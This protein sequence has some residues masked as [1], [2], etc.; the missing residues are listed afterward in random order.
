MRINSKSA[1]VAVALL[2]II[3]FNSGCREEAGAGPAA[4]DFLLS[5]LS[6]KMISLDQ[7]R[8]S[9]VILDF[10]ATWCG[11]CRMS[12][13]ELVKLN[14]KHGDKG[15][16]ILGVSLDDP[17]RATDEQLRAFKEQTKINYRI[18]RYN[19]KLVQDYFGTGRVSIPTM[20]VID[21]EGKISD[22]LVGFKAGVVEKSLNR[23][24]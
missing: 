11:P 18:L 12:I 7:F 24:L 1:I 10:W 8:G 5:D 21:R 4:P 9:V 16:V 6:G 22:K 3:F 17:Q 15:L 20:F 13:P 2:A 14:A 19:Q 23:L